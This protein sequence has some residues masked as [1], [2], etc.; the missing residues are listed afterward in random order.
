M[1]EIRGMCPSEL[2]SV[3][4]M[5]A[6]AFSNT[7]ASFFDH[8]VKHD[9]QLQPEHTRLLLDDKTICSCVRIY[10]RDIYCSD[11]VIRVG[12]I[13]DV[14]TD[15][16]FQGKGYASRLMKESINFMKENGAVVSILFTRINSFYKEF[17][18][19]TLPTLE[20]QCDLPPERPDLLWRQAILERDLP[21]LSQIYLQMNNRRTG[22]VKRNLTYWKKQTGF[23]RLDPDLFWIHEK[24]D[25]LLC[26]AR[27]RRYDNILKIMEFGYKEGCEKQVRDL[28]LTMTNYTQKNKFVLTYLSQIELQVFRGLPVKI[29]ENRSLMIRLIQLNRLSI[30]RELFKSRQILFWEA[31]RF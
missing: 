27:G 16:A 19:F 22:P 17:G 8:Q 25:T 11:K 28:I 7:P 26:Y 29:S 18:Y 13:G 15:P 2:K 5:L 12:G 31:D 1:I 4:N 20:I 21:A 24:N 6:R 9:P 23:P 14:G 10:F 3:H 30:F